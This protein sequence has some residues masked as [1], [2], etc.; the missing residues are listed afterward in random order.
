MKELSQTDYV[1]YDYAN[2]HVVSFSNGEAIIFGSKEEAQDDC[3]GYERVIS[4]TELPENWKEFL[5][6]QINK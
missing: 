4:C 2:D 5:L 6:E 3:R 1:I